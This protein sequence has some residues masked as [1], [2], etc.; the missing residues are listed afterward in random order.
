[1]RV[2]L[3]HRLRYGTGRRLQSILSDAPWSNHDL[4]SGLILLGIGGLLFYDPTIYTK[5]RTLNFI[6]QSGYTSEWSGLFLFSVGYGL[7]V[8]LWCLAPPFPLRIAARMF[9]A[10]CFLT[11][12]FSSWQ[13]AATPSA[14]TFSLI[15]LWSVWGVLR[16]QT[17]GR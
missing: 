1:M 13:F 15:A 16:T 7:A 9:Y 17:S 6:A 5:L 3:Y 10:F 2:P 14:I 11:L 8:T 12:A 4:L